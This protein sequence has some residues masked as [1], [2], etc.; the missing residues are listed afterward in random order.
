MMGISVDCFMTSL[1][2]RLCSRSR[3]QVMDETYQAFGFG[4]GLFALSGRLGAVLQKPF[5]FEVQAFADIL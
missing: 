4:S 2:I 1:A 3:M 5:K